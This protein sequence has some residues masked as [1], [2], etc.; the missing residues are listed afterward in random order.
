MVLPNSQGKVDLPALF[1]EL[2]RRGMNEVHVEAGT[3]LNGSLLAEGC[4]DE[5]LIYLA[6]RLI[7]GTGLGM[8][9]LPEMTDLAQT[10]TLEIRDVARIGADLR[11]MARTARTKGGS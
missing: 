9:D 3:R 8:F 2:A 5:L 11:V 7:G 6:P 10:P 1:E 4:V